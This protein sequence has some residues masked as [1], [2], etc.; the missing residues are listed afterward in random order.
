MII[1]TMASNKITIKLKKPNGINV[2]NTDGLTY[3]SSVDNES[4]DLVLTDPPYIISHNTG[5]NAL[6]NQFSKIA[7]DHLDPVKTIEDWTQ[8][9]TLNHI[10]SDNDQEKYLKY[11]TIYGKKYGIKTN[12]GEWDSNFTL[13]EL[14][15]FIQQFYNKLKKGGTL[16][17]FF[18]LWKISTL[19]QM[20]EKYGFKQIRYLEWIKT[21]PPPINSHINY[22]TNCREIALS[23]VKSGKPTFNSS[24]DN[25]IYYY[26]IQNG[27][28]HCHPTQKNL[29]LF[30]EL[31]NKHSNPN[32][33]VLDCFLGSG[34]TLFACQKT[35]RQFRG[36]EMSKDYYD[37]IMNLL[38]N[39]N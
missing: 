38:H 39:S 25:A 14:D 21:N 9:K 35:N 10:T 32:D 31:I 5:M 16:I 24:Y 11:G 6:H 8:Y 7:K 34:T 2:E 30:I 15:K 20:L 27:K 23:G 18:D 36:C 37:H 26:P 22:L 28:S 4:I 3:L 33:V 1:D 13:D 19:K 17:I 12:Y 29:D